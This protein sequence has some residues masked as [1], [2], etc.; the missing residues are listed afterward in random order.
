MKFDNTHYVPCLRWKLGEYQAVFRLS[1]AV[2]NKFTPLIEIPEIGWD[3]AKKKEAKTIDQQVGS[4]PQRVCDKWGVTF[5]FIDM[6]YVDLLGR[7]DNGQHPLMF[8]F[9]GLRQGKCCGIPIVYLDS[10]KLH[11]QQLRLIQKTDKNGICLRIGIKQALN[12]NNSLKN[13]IDD[14]MNDLRMPLNEMHLILDIGTPNF[15]PLEGFLKLLKIIIRKF[16]YLNSWKTFS[17]I[18]TSFPE[19]MATLR[20]GLEVL[21]RYEWQLYKLIIRDFK[22]EGTRLPTFGDYAIGHPKLLN[23]DMRLIKPAA[24]IR[25]SIDDEWCIIKGKNTRDNG[26]SQ[27]KELS[28]Q[29]VASPYYCGKSFSYG[30]EYIKNCADG[31]IK[32]G[33]L[34]IWRQVGTNHHIQ[35]VISDLA[36]LYAS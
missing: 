15:V 6:R 17:I 24:T 16:P 35:K 7:L 32:P 26:F 10:N 27:Y 9:D 22:R 31:K 12:V 8:V 33:H 3:F 28:K 11:R 30:D 21:P 4:F 20:R 14:L 5:C 13:D 2:K 1:A 29:L 34:P 19:T 23:I 25:Y 36:S 18:A